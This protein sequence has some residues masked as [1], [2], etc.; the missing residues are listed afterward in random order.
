LREIADELDGALSAGGGRFVLDNTYLTR[1]ARSYVIEDGGPTWGADE[2]H[3][4][5]HA[6]C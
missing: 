2:L 5:R 1:A 3:V 4:A 6:A